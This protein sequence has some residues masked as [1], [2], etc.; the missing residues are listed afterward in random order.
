MNAMQETCREKIART[1]G[2]VPTGTHCQTSRCGVSI[3]HGHRIPDL[4]HIIACDE[5]LAD[6]APQQLAHPS[7]P[8]LLLF[9]RAL[10]AHDLVCTLEHGLSLIPREH[11][12]GKGCVVRALGTRVD[13]DEIGVDVFDLVC[14][15][16]VGVGVE[17]D[18]LPDLFAVWEG[19]VDPVEEDG[20]WGDLEEEVLV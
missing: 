3:Q 5:P 12:E 6:H 11:P 16:A 8:E 13:D 9:L 17:A 2:R 18:D 14:T 20:R 19:G 15:D 4:L 7:R 10:I 1:V